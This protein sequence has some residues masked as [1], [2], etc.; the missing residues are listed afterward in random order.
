MFDP[1]LFLFKGNAGT[2]TT[3]KIEQKV[4]LVQLEIYPMCRPQTATLLIV[5][6][7]AGRQE[8]A[9]CPLR[10]SISS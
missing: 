2:T 8:L 6:C 5:P 7:F 3:T 9:G 1:E 4:R 10:G